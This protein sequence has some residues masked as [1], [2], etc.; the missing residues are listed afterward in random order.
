[1]AWGAES[2]P[3]ESS[4]TP[5]KL[6]HYVYD[7]IGTPQLLLNQSQEVVWEAESKAWGET[8]VEPRE[9]KEGVV[10]NH[11]FQGQYYDEESEL[12]YN[13]FRYYDPELGRFIS[14]DPIGLMGGINVYQYA[15]NPV[16]WVDPWGWKR[17]SIFNGRR[18][19]LKAIHDLERN[20]Y[21]VIAEEVTMKVNKSRS[22]I[23]ADI[24]ASDRNGG[25]HV[26][27][28]KHGK[29]RLTK[30]QKKAKVFDMDSPSN[31]CE[32]GGGSLRPSQGK[33][34]DFILDTRNRP[35]LGNKGQKFKDTTFHILK[36]R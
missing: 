2:A 33:D 1:M 16:E 24:V 5:P 25:I 11:R 13:T 14:Q 17:L 8:Y 26:F 19:V 3:R 7:Q 35:G 29:G 23:R 10:N 34:S 31:T 32:R 15:P 6:Y 9:V 28:V 4:A 18:G 12:H 20:G 30:N 36:Y 22:R 27:E 21:A